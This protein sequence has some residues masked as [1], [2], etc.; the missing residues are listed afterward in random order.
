M[1][2]LPNVHIKPVHL[3]P[4][5]AFR[6]TSHITCRYRPPKNKQ[7]NKKVE[8][9]QQKEKQKKIEIPSGNSSLHLKQIANGFLNSYTPHPFLKTLT[10]KTI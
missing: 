6:K 9:R 8:K 4:T 5:R 3:V 2:F 10:P 7:K 1:S